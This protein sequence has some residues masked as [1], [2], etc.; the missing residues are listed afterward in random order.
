MTLHIANT[1]TD[2]LG[3]LQNREQKKAKLTVFDFQTDEGRK[4]LRYHKLDRAADPKFASVS[5]DMDLRIIVHR[6]GGSVVLCYIDHHDEAYRWAERRRLEV[7]PTTGAA[8]LVELV[9][10]VEEVGSDP[11]GGEAT[12]S[13]SDTPESEASSSP[14]P[15]LRPEPSTAPRRLPL[16]DYADEWLLEYGVPHD[17]L[18]RLKDAD[19]DQLLDLAMHLPEEAAEIVLTIATGKV[20]AKPTA[21]SADADPFAHP[22]AQRRFRRVDSKEELEAALDAPFDAWR[23]FLHPAQRELV[24]RSYGGPAR[25]AGSAGTGKTIVALHRA[26]HLLR[27]DPEATVLLTTFGGALANALATTFRQLIAHEP[28]L[29]ERVTVEPLDTVARRLFRYQAAGRRI[30]P[31][32]EVRALVQEL[33]ASEGVSV[34]EGFAWR[35]WSEVVDAWQLDTW[36]AYQEVPR[37]GRGA[38]L[39]AGKREE[40]WRVFAKVRDTLREQNLVTLDQ[41]YGALTS[42]YRLGELR[43]PYTHFVVDEAQDISVAQLRLLAAMAGGRDDALFF[44]G[45]LGQRIFQAPFSWRSLG[46]DVRGRSRTLRINYRTSH[47]IRLQADRLLDPEIA[48]ADGNLERRDVAQSVFN[49]PPPTLVAAASEAEEATVVGDWL[50]SRVVEGFAP[51]ELAVFVRSDRE[52]ARARLSV[53]QA[54]LPVNELDS[55][56]RIVEGAITIGTMHLAK[57]L[58][59]RAVAVMA[60]DEEIIPDISRLSEV[61]SPDE[62]YRTERYL[63]YVACTRARDRLLISCAG[64]PSEFVEDLLGR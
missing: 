32:R 50:T 11:T 10:R 64:E 59:F 41:A 5:V 13:A 39:N 60:V 35:E 54:E 25:V 22:D 43:S 33:A 55:A 6:D 57:G 46:V 52:L 29:M 1:F 28:Q 63:L 47:Q 53:G 9:E 58:E 2:S 21:A 62:L 56:L 18:A 27:G 51:H 12:Q 49:G 42:A 37:I 30:A 4:G 20:P 34:P 26:A 61:N 3:K 36:A 40:L 31:E 8:Q 16:A 14:R 48:D 38:P 24:A 7:H 15:A 45:D 23:I 44:A 19:E 17:W